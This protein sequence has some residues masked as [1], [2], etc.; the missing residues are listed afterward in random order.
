MTHLLSLCAVAAALTS[1]AAADEDAAARRIAELE[2]EVA[3]LEAE[4]AEL[5]QRLNITET[6]KADLETDRT[7]LEQLA[8]MTATGELVESR[9]ARIQT[10]YDAEADRTTVTSVAERLEGP[11]GLQTVEHRL[12]L[13]YSFPGR[14]LRLDNQPQTIAASVYT[15]ANSDD[16]YKLLKTVTLTIDGEAVEV[17]V[18]YHVLH[19]DTRKQSTRY[20]SGFRTTSTYD[21]QLVLTLDRATFHRISAARDVSLT[22]F[23]TRFT[24]T[25]DNLATFVAMRERLEMGAK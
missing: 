9:L 15:F 2:A 23:K 20:G 14:S 6:A 16:R 4:N 5:R 11:G 19:T 21:E 13:S 8:G 1:A 3:R 7:R 25:R 10:A 22:L 17:P 24:L 12:A 18:T